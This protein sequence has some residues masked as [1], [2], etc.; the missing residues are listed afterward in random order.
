MALFAILVLAF[1]AWL[2]YRLLRP[3]DDDEAQPTDPRH[4]TRQRT[5][6][7]RKERPSRSKPGKT[8]EMLECRHCGVHAEAST[9]VR[10]GG[11]WY[12]CREHAEADA[13]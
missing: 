8:R 9:G 11:R 3:R 10:T 12:C 2:M 1:G 13:G 4:R 7:R 5:R 6:Q